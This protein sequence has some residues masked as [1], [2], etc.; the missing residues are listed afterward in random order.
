MLVVA[1]AVEL[2]HQELRGQVIAETD[3]VRRLRVE[4]RASSWHPDPPT[5]EAYVAAAKSVMRPLLGMYARQYGEPYRLGIGRRRRTGRRL[6]PS[7]QSVFESFVSEANKTVLH[8]LDWEQFY[9]LIRHFSQHRVHCNPDHLKRLL[10][11][12]GFR[13]GYADELAGIYLHGRWLL[14]AFSRRSPD[15]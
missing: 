9:V 5:Y 1:P 13:E 10:L 8:T 12:V 4:I 2:P 15:W 6:P 7:A 11:S 14:K 3:S